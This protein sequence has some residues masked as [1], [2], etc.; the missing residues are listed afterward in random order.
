MQD[1]EGAE[2]AEGAKNGREEMQD[3]RRVRDDGAERTAELL[4][5]RSLHPPC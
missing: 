3:G 4:V 1:T 2:V 5:V